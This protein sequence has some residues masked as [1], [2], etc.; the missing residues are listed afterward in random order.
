MSDSQSPPTGKRRTSRDEDVVSGFSLHNPFPKLPAILHC[1]EAHCNAHHHRRVHSHKGIEITVV[2]MGSVTWSI[3][4]IK[5]RQQTGEVT[6]MPAHH[7]HATAAVEHPEYKSLYTALDLT[8]FEETALDTML[9]SR[10]A[11]NLGVATEFE[12]VLRIL[13]YEALGQRGSTEVAKKVA[14]LL[15]AMIRAHITPEP[16]RPSH[17]PCSLPIQR[18]IDFMHQHR[19]REVSLAEIAEAVHHTRAYFA[20]KFKREVGK[21]PHAF[22]RTLR[23]E[24]ARDALRSPNPS[25]TQI[26]FEFGFSSSQ[27]LSTLFQKEFGFTPTAWRRRSISTTADIL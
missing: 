19:H 24:A 13:Y 2:T 7:R 18:A 8:A 10:P 21:S 11:W 14:E 25:V 1:G 6:I 4:S 22:H 17:T 26:A 15:I 3:G 12:P 16:P 9:R 20:A 23:L 5:L 27:H